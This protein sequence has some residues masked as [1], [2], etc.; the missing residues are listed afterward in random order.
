MVGRYLDDPRQGIP[1]ERDVFVAQSEGLRDS[2]TD[3]S[4]QSDVTLHN[5]VVRKCQCPVLNN[6][7]ARVHAATVMP[8][9]N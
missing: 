8:A 4:S 7:A 5:K 2:A 9:I 3:A 6:H 1:Q